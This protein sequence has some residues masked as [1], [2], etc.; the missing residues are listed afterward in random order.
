VGVVHRSDYNQYDATVKIAQM[1]CQFSSLEQSQV[2]NIRS[3]AASISLKALWENFIQY[4]YEA[5][6]IALTQKNLRLGKH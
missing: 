2:E 6:N 3:K 5:Y 1:I 4:Y